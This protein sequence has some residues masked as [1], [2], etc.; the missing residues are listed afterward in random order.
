M[1]QTTPTRVQ[2]VDRIEGLICTYPCKSAQ[3]GEALLAHLVSHP[4][5]QAYQLQLLGPGGEILQEWPP[6]S[7]FDA[8][9]VRTPQLYRLLKQKDAVLRDSA[10]AIDKTKLILQQSEQL[11]ERTAR[12][13]QEWRRV[14][15]PQ[16]PHPGKKY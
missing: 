1:E 4:E 2:I 7:R 6:A 14:Y 13:W 15:E 16:Q 3:E 12:L 5:N 10:Q 9:P 8:T 11:H